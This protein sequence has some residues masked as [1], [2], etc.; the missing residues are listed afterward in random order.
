M[1]VISSLEFKSP[2]CR[3]NKTCKL[4]E[5]NFMHIKL[6]HTKLRSRYI[7]I[8]FFFCIFVCKYPSKI[9]IL[10]MPINKMRTKKI[11]HGLH[12]VSNWKR[13]SFLSMF[14]SLKLF[15]LFFYFKNIR[16]FSNFWRTFKLRIL[17]KQQLNLSY[18]SNYFRKELEK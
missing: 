8:L 2:R 10:K 9:F 12:D 4:H 13:K 7:F 5:I 3:N 17:R 1:Q 14:L 15:L 6:L 11:M 18:R 16:S